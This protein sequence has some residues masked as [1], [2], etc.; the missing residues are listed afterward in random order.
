[1]S[2]E[3]I[4]RMQGE[5]EALEHDFRAVEQTYGSNALNFTETRNYLKKLLENAKVLRFLS[6]R[7]PDLLVEFQAIAA[8]EAI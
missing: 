8:M 1:M 3:E 4:A 6:S 7:H 2:A 5:M